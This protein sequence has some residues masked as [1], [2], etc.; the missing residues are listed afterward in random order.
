MAVHIP[1]GVF[2]NFFLLILNN[3]R[4]VLGPL[5]LFSLTPLF[6]LCVMII[7]NYSCTHSPQDFF[8]FFLSDPQGLKGGPVAPVAVFVYVWFF[9]LNL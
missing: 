2:F 4:G 1:H 5:G 9:P 6:F 3:L 7:F 8:Q